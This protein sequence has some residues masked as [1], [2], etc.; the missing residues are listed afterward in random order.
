MYVQ[1]VSNDAKV[2]VEKK[3]LLRK[4]T[5]TATLDSTRKVVRDC[6]SHNIQHRYFQTKGN[7]K[8]T[9]KEFRNVVA[10]F[11][12]LYARSHEKFLNHE[13]PFYILNFKFS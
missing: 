9:Q 11:K 2:V 6:T 10:A 3:K 5:V 8:T 12:T 13:S 7:G 1:D 4:L